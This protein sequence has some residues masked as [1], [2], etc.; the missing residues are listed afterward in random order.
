MLKLMIKDTASQ[1]WV[2][3]GQHKRPCNVT[4]RLYRFFLSTY[5]LSWWQVTILSQRRLLLKVSASSQK[6]AEL[7]K[8]LLPRK[9][10]LQR[11]LIQSMLTKAEIRWS[12]TKPTNWLVH[13]AKTQFSL[14]ICPVW[15]ESSLCVV[16]VAKDPAYFNRL[17]CWFFVML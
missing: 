7:W 10:S 16:R 11:K 12:R 14:A 13:S 3:G 9:E 6:V 17:L 8:I 15:S 5:R 2:Q 4:G 1:A